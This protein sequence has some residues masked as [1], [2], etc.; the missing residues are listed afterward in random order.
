MAELP[1]QRLVYAATQDFPVNGS[2]RPSPGR[3]PVHLLVRGDINKPGELVGPRTLGCI[4][5]L[6]GELVPVDA[7]ES[8]RR[9]ALARWLSD[10]QRSYLAKHCQPGLAI[11]FRAGLCDTPNDFGHMGETPSHLELLDWLAVWFRD[12]A[13]GSLK[14]LHRLLV[15]SSTYRRATTDGPAAR[16]DTDNR[17]FWRMNRTRLAGEQIRDAVLQIAVASILPWAVHRPCNSSTAARPRSCRA[18]RIPRL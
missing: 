12:D 9:A 17:L 5:G 6:G 1:A 18:A 15:T 14:A 13:K 11:P 3:R 16:V 7:N 8:A 4:P 10:G 2:F